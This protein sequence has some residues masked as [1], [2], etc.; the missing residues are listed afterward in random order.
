MTPG[1]IDHS[2][3]NLSDYLPRE[4]GRTDDGCDHTLPTTAYL[5]IA[6]A[7]KPKQTTRQPLRWTRIRECPVVVLSNE[8]ELTP[9]F[10]FPLTLC[11]LVGLLRIV[12]AARA[13]VLTLPYTSEDV[14]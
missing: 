2:W 6:V 4:T 10:K 12:K 7:F 8:T 1:K 9:F 13:Q 3:E 5:S 14:S 11:L